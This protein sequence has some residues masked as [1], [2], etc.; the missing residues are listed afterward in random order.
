MADAPLAKQL[1]DQQGEQRLQGRDRLGAGQTRI[2]NG[3]GQVEVEQQGKEQE[4]AGDL[5]A[6]L[7][8]VL[9]GQCA[10]VGDVGHDGAVVGVLTR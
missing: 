8:P 10:D 5:G 4:E 9:E 3:L 2:G 7:P 1:G 6:E